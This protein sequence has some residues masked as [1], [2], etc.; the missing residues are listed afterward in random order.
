[1]AGSFIDVTIHSQST[2]SDVG[3]WPTC[4]IV[5]RMARPRVSLKGL[6]RSGEFYTDTLKAIYDWPHL[7]HQ[8]HVRMLLEAPCLKDGTGREIRR[9][10]DTVQQHLRALKTMGCEP[11]GPFIASVLELKLD[12][13]TSFEW[14]K[15]SQSMPGIP[16]YSKML[17]FLNLRAQAPEASS[18]SCSKE[19]AD[20]SIT[21]FTANTSN[22][23]SFPLCKKEQHFL[24]ACPQFKTLA[25]ERKMSTVN[26]TTSA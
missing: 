22:L 10:H 21:S 19:G 6:S 20:K 18:T 1:M 3:N 23:A 7:I 11:S 24:F 13:N 16:H 26:Q 25:H 17:E 5:S 14:Q 4:V 9:L 8:S 2:L 12:Q 15:F